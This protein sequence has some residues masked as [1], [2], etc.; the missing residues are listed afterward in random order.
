MYPEITAFFDSNSG[1]TRQRCPLI[2][3]TLGCKRD[4]KKDVEGD[5][6]SIKNAIRSWLECLMAEQ[7]DDTPAVRILF[8]QT[9]YEVE[10]LKPEDM[11]DVTN[12]L[13]E[14]LNILLREVIM[15]MWKPKYSEPA[16]FEDDIGICVFDLTKEVHRDEAD[17]ALEEEVRDMAL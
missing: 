4:E 2:R 6:E 10:L 7:G 3:V 13:G 8:Q 15:S 5:K 11:A 1:Y 17:D 9:D 14:Q 12:T 16:S